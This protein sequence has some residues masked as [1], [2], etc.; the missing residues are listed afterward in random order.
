VSGTYSKHGA[1]KKLTYNLVGK[2][3]VSKHLDDLDV[4]GIITLK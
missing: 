1:D 2:S 4:D 3:N